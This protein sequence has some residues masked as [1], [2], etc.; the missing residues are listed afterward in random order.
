MVLDAQG[1]KLS[2]Y[3][4][5]CAQAF[6]FYEEHVGGKVTMMMT[7]AERPNAKDVPTDQ[8]NTILY[9]RMS[10]GEADLIGSDVP[11]DH[12][13]PSVPLKDTHDGLRGFEICDPDGYVLF[14]SR[15]R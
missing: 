12:F 8:K 1:D 3:G 9:A 6:R 5:N 4:G 11:S 2:S 14:F 13:Q 15:P 10:T 7:Q